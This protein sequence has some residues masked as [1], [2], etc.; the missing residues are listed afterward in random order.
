MFSS[1]P[2]IDVTHVN[3]YQYCS[4]RLYTLTSSSATQTHTPHTPLAP[5]S[6]PTVACD[7]CVTF[8]SPTAIAQNI[9]TFSNVEH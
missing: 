6:P 7:P 9:S 5:L 1:T 2:T 4:F 3:S 8:L